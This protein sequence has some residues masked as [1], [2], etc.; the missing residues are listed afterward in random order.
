MNT[1]M[2]IEAE[3]TNEVEKLREQFP[4]TKDL[5][6]EVCGLL[7]FRYGIQP[8]ANKLYQFV[9]KGTMSTPAEALNQFWFDLRERSRVQIDHPGLPDNLKQTAGDI[10]S[11]LWKAAQDSANESYKTLTKDIMEKMA[12]AE[13]GIQNIKVELL[14]KS[15]A[16]ESLEKELHF[17][18]SLLVTAEKQISVDAEI[19]ANQKESLKTLQNEKALLEADLKAVRE[20]FSS[21]VD[22]LHSSLKIS[23][24]RYQALESRALLDTDREKQ[25]SMKLGKEIVDLKRALI[26]EQSASKKQSVKFQ[27]ILNENTEKVGTLKGQLKECQ[28]LHLISTNKLKQVENKLS[29]KSK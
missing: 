12:A 17:T 2:A 14:S 28:R 23:D 25:L 19:S 22:K 20:N 18:K 7:F 21:E 5:Y 8:T 29:I 4:Q 11:T 9:R 1:T 15:E 24:Q 3:I 13:L 6:R 16:Y 27:L 10:L 26:N